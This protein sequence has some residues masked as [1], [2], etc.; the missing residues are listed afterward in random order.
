MSRAGAGDKASGCSCEQPYIPLLMQWS[1]TIMRETT[2]I[3]RS[4]G[5]YC[6]IKFPNDSLPPWQ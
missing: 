6:I 2:A 4:H 1:T 5:E 3:N